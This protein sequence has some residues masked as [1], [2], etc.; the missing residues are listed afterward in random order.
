MPSTESVLHDVKICQKFSAEA[1]QDGGIT[2]NKMPSLDEKICFIRLPP[3]T[4]QNV[5]QVVTLEKTTGRKF[6][7]EFEREK[8]DGLHNW[9]EQANYRKK[10]SCESRETFFS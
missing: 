5:W 8:N 6:E 1:K 2:K 10:S 3:D 7:G 4:L 9:Q